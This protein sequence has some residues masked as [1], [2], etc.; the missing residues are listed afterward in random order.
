MGFMNNFRANPGFNQNQMSQQMQMNQQALAQQGQF[1]RQLQNANAGAMGG[2][3]QLAGMLMQ[4]AQGGGPNPA[5]AQLANTTGQNVANQTAMMASG[6]GAGANAG[7]MGRQAAQQGAA[8]QQQAAGQAATLSAQQQLGA[9]SQLGGLYGQQIGQTQGALGQ[10]MQGSL[11]NQG[12]L[13]GAQSSANQV[14]AQVEGQNAA[15]QNKLMG[16]IFGAAGSAFGMA[17]G[18]EIPGVATSHTMPQIQG[19]NNAM[20]SLKK[21]ERSPFHS[22][23]SGM[24][25][26]AAS[27]DSAGMPE[28]SGNVFR[29]DPVKIPLAAN[30]GAVVPGEASFSGDN[31]K[32]D[33]VP[34]MLSPKEIVLPRSVTLADNAPQKAAQFVAAIKAKKG[35][36]K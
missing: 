16:S 8:T 5:L 27:G 19:I 25:K 1:T 15:S 4:Q 32:N 12:Q 33:T 35:M 18:G 6:R 34:A 22:F 14:N 20:D 21:S 28:M 2:Q 26:G 11:A 13:L 29:P 7:L 17:N 24:G 3:N 31:L 10:Q 9:Q 36:K 30:R 23:L